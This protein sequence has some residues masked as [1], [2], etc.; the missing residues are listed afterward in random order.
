MNKKVCILLATYNGE[1]YLEQ[2]LDSLIIQTYQDFVCYIHDD[3][4]TD[5]TVAIIEKYCQ[6]DQQRFCIV[7]GEK[8]GGAK[9]NFFYLLYH[10]INRHQY[11]MFCDQDDVWIDDKI[12]KSVRAIEKLEQE[13]EEPCLVYCDMKVVDEKLNVISDSFLQYNALI[14]KHIT[15]DRAIMKCYAAG[16]SMVI[17]NKL[18]K[19]LVIKENKE[20]IMHDW[21]A[22]MLAAAVG[23]IGRISEPLLL[24]RQHQDNTLGAKHISKLTRFC[25]IMSR[26]ILFKQ[27]RI[28]K[29][30]LQV[31]INQ[32]ALCKNIP[33]VMEKHEDLIVKADLYNSM[34]KIERMR[35]V[36]KYHL[37]QN[38][39]SKL[40]SCIC[41]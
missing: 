21:W 41:A 27:Y 30:G 20:V 8:Q 6:K 22:M 28:T 25:E 1:K 40:W 10:V 14:C 29:M 9:Q 33:A 26:I 32:L 35:F 31:R 2:L 3:G 18:A 15:F 16:C 37:Y 7:E 19:L 36:F 24:Y 12:E 34:K 17:N 39:W 4:S 13:R 38:N 11:I 5:D 23:K